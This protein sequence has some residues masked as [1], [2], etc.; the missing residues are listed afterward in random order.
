MTDNKI[1]AICPGVSAEKQVDMQALT[2]KIVQLPPEAISYIAG[3]VEM[4]SLLSNNK[5][6]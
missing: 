3:A 1:K 5:G 4:A 2:D 6:A